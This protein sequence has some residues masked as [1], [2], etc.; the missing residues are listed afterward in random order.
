MMLQTCRLDYSAR[1]SDAD[2]VSITV[3]GFGSFTPFIEYYFSDF[4]DY[5]LVRGYTRDDNIRSAP[6]DWRLSPG[7]LSLGN[8]A[9]IQFAESKTVHCVTTCTGVSII[10]LCVFEHLVVLFLTNI[11][12]KQLREVGIECKK[13][14]ET[15][16]VTMATKVK[17]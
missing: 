14:K 1:Y 11:K 17:G 12:K 6:Y 2:G 10:S 8:T 7:K 9:T 13:S 3:P 15:R 5:F 16:I 4:L